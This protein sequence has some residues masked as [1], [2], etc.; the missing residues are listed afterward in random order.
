MKIC[1]VSRGKEIYLLE[2]NQFLLIQLLSGKNL[3]GWGDGGAIT[4]NKALKDRLLKIRNVGSAKKYTHDLIGYNSRLNPVN[5]IVLSQKLKH[6][7]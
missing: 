7:K 1:S 2:I 3:G 4:T 6:L 5:G